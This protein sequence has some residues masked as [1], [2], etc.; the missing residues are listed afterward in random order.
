VE[1]IPKDT[2]EPAFAIQSS[3]HPTEVRIQMNLDKLLRLNQVVS[4]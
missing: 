4:H 2:T 1:P 3:V